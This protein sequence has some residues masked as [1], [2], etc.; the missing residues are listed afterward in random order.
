[1]NFIF[2]SLPDAYSVCNIENNILILS[3]SM[4]IGGVVRLDN[5]V[6]VNIAIKLLSCTMVCGLFHVILMERPLVKAVSSF[7]ITVF[8]I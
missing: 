4:R 6:V 5:G 2:K 1:M 8:D 7:Y 3:I